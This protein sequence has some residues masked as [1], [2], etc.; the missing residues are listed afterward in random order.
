MRPTPENQ[1]PHAPERL[2]LADLARG[3]AAAPGGWG[4]ISA[5]ERPPTQQ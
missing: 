4:M 2:S 3:G 1:K 5:A